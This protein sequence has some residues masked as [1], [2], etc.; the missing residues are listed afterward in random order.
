MSMSATLQTDRQ[1]V[2]LLALTLVSL[3]ASQG[4]ISGFTFS[5]SPTLLRDQG[6][7]LHHV[8]LMSLA[9]LPWAFSFLMAPYIDRHK[10]IGR[11]H[12]RS[13]IVPMQLALPGAVLAL[14]ACFSSNNFATIFVLTFMVGLLSAISDVGAHGLAVEQLSSQQRGWG[15]G[16]QVG[17]YWIGSLLGSGGV[18]MLQP[19]LGTANAI[20][21]IAV[22]LLIVLIPV[23]LYPE[24]VL[25]P[26]ALHARHNPSVRSFLARRSSRMLLLFIVLFDLGR[27]A[28]M[29]MQGPF[30]IDKGL[31][32]ADVGFLN[33]TVGVI[34]GLLGSVGGSLLVGK[35]RRDYAL[36]L[37]AI[38]QAIAFG[39]YAYLAA[40]EYLPKSLL[41]VIFA[42]QYFSFSAAIVALYAF[43]MDNCTK[44]QAS[45]DFSLPYCFGNL[46]VIGGGALSGFS[47][48]KLGYQMHFGVCFAV[49]AAAAIAT[50]FLYRRIVALRNV[51]LAAEPSQA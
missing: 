12:R 16:L 24:G 2:F 20:S 47:A 6:M 1:P 30:L 29:S 4:L 9:L 40:I 27:A 50:P 39:A 25:Q 38:L 23:M 13:W 17:G 5:G 34:A 49:C 46:M 35:L 3:Y 31:S 51:E 21:L 14:A 18:L 15:N 43:I 28:A 32:V 36:M 10:F 48:S 33:G 42:L 11:T 45:T 8:G 41:A 7:S 19:Q 44:G 26:E 22:A 37:T